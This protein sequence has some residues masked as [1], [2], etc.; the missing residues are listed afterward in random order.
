MS[1]PEVQQVA[2]ENQVTQAAV[3]AFPCYSSPYLHVLQMA[4]P[5]IQEFLMFWT[6][7]RAPDAAERQQIFNFIYVP[8]G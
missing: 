4:D 1:V 7:N 8:T 5:V 3:A 2:E 6:R